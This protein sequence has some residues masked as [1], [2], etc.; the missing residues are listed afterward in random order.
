MQQVSKTGIYTRVLVKWLD[1]EDRV[2]DDAWQ[3]F[4]TVSILHTSHV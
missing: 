3:I 1:R 2:T 4:S